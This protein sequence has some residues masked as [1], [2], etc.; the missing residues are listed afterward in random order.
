MVLIIKMG[1]ISIINVQV[2]ILEL[3]PSV[4][5]QITLSN[6][7]SKRNIYILG[8]TCEIFAVLFVVYLWVLDK[9]PFEYV[10]LGLMK[11]SALSAIT[12]E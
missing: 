7:L 12:I 1:E 8:S 9:K 4:N 6:F 3:K 10:N 2:I 5:E 11:L